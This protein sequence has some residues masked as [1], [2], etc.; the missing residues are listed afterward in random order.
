MTATKKKTRMRAF[1]VNNP[2]DKRST[3]TPSTRRQGV[4]SI[5]MPGRTH[6]A[7]AS[8][9]HTN[10]SQTRRVV[11]WLGFPKGSCALCCCPR[12]AKPRPGHTEHT[13]RPLAPLRRPLHAAE[14]PRRTA[15]A[16]HVA[17]AVA[18]SNLAGEGGPGGCVTSKERVTLRGLPIT[19]SVRH[20]SPSG[21]GRRL[22]EAKGA[23]VIGWR[24]G[25]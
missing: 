13:H 15:G 4:A 20:T 24:R 11:P 19:I 5:P 7:C 9:K 25:P 8:T 1:H 22:G 23:D 17:S 3:T 12:A 16:K 2:R 14:R 18:V 21:P 6:G 10:E